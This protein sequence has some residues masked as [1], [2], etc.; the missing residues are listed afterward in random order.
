LY[1]VQLPVTVTVFMCFIL[2][3]VDIS[4]SQINLDAGRLNVT[5]VSSIVFREYWKIS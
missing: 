4:R 1:A 2:V 5:E 3:W